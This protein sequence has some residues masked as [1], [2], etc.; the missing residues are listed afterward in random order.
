MARNRESYEYSLN[1][2]KFIL[3]GDSITERSFNQYPI[4]DFI[5]DGFDKFVD[6]ESKLKEI[7]DNLNTPEFSFG[8]GLSFSYVRRLDV[9]NRGFSGYNSGHMKAMIDKLLYLDHDSQPEGSKCVMA[10]L[11][12]GTNDAATAK[13][14]MI[15]YDEYV[16][17]MKYIIEK[18]TDKGIKL[19]I[20]G[21][22]HHAAH[23]WE[24]LN[25]DEVLD[26]NLTRSNER[27]L[28]Y[29]NGLE[30]LCK[31]LN[32]PFV[33][34]YE[35]FDNYK[36]NHKDLNSDDLFLDGI[37]LNG[38][39]QKIVYDSIVESIKQN[40][41]DLHFQNEKLKMR[42]PDWNKITIED[43]EKL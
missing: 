20:I 26:L 29:S 23:L 12:L 7:K 34:L 1:F 42:L 2:P 37:H 32:L 10:T 35:K 11:F 13:P 31:S 9:V 16:E 24:P 19:I 22:A 43:I 25:Q 4:Q 14:D 15:E 17:N 30:K 8:A 18:I 5:A 39:G 6:S 3:F 40:Y 33:N 27:N 38:R 28:Q 41:P 36:S 21:P